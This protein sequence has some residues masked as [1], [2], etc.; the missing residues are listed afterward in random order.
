MPFPPLRVDLV[1]DTVTQPT[2]KMREA[3]MQAEVGDEQRGEDP[4]TNQL[5]SRVAALLGKEAA[6]YLPS[7]VMC[8]QI[9]ILVHCRPGDEILA[10]TSA[11]IIGSE[12]GGSAAL[13]GAMIRP[14]AG[15]EGI[16]DVDDIADALRPNKRNAPRTKLVVVEQTVNRGGGT[17]WP[18]QRLVDIAALTRTL[19]L[20]VHMDG[21]RLMNAVVASGVSAAEFSAPCDSVWVDFSKGLGCPGGA[22]LA[23][24]AE[25]I[26]QAWI[27]KHR[28]G[29]AMRQSGMM[30]AA[31]I[32]ALDHHVDR[33]SED[34]ANAQRFAELIAD[35]PGIRLTA[36][37]VQ[38]NLIFFDVQDTGM[39]GIEVAEKLRA[40]GC[41]I[42][43]ESTYCMRAVTHLG[44][45]RTDVEDV[46]AAL[47]EL[48]GA[49]P[50]L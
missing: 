1:S 3:I 37:R 8:N 6:V 49:S 43:V 28:L 40:K 36:E 19:K 32:Y 35:I 25:F 15:R 50:S 38:T 9:A 22:V 10:D 13:A 42:G 14:L 12:A 39:T 33:L 2:A 44:V 20:A 16:F 11:H 45:S 31:G 18:L 29:G 24:S 47:R 7:G 41:R 26:E 5:C 23:G 27:W 46:A 48:L 34:H 30:A 17:V 21:A 4:T